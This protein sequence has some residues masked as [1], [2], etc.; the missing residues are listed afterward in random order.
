MVTRTQLGLGMVY[1]PVLWSG[2]GYWLNPHTRLTPCRRAW[3]RI[4]ARPY[5][6]AHKIDSGK[7]QAFRRA[8]N[9]CSC[10]RGDLFLRHT[11]ISVFGYLHPSLAWSSSP[12]QY[13]G[14]ACMRVAL[15][16]P[17]YLFKDWNWKNIPQVLSIRS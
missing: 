10:F 7:T 16:Q 4:M 6:F 1:W 8:K 12:G 13:D 9:R 11:K 14:A 15:A 3:R 2:K 5:P 17:V